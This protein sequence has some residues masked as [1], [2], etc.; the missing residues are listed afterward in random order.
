[1]NLQ[2][3]KLHGHVAQVALEAGNS[4]QMIFAHYR[5]LVTQAEAM[6]WFSIL[7]EVVS[8][9]IPMPKAAEAL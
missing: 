7:P 9:I 5:Q 2:K 6:K 3:K 8:N 4:P 1:M